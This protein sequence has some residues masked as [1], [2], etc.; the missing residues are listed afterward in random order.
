MVNNVTIQGRLTRDPMQRSAKDGTVIAS[1]RFAH[2]VYR[3]GEWHA[4]FMNGV[5][6]GKPAENFLK[7]CKKGDSFILEGALIDSS[8]K[9]KDGYDVNEVAVKGTKYTYLG[10]EAEKTS[11]DQ[12][13][14]EAASADPAAQAVEDNVIN[15]LNEDDLPF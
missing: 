3:N 4:F 2:N 5:L 9:N 6:F 10:R 14:D 7:G 12:Y 13:K 11:T 1:F 15:N 8:H